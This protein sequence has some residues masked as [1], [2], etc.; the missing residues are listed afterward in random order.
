MHANGTN[1]HR[2]LVSA[3]L[4]DQLCMGSNR[5]LLTLACMRTEGYCSRSMCVCVCVCVCV[6]RHVRIFSVTVDAAFFKLGE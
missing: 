1:I 5:T 2:V 6:S 3:W 4:P